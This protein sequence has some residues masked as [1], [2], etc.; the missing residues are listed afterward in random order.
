MDWNISSELILKDLNGHLVD[1]IK[2]TTD[3]NK[4]IE[5]IVK[6]NENNDL[7]FIGTNDYVNLITKLLNKISPGMEFIVQFILPMFKPLQMKIDIENLKV[8]EA[9]IGNKTIKVPNLSNI[10]DI[11]SLNFSHVSNFF[12][13]SK[14]I[15]SIEESEEEDEVKEEEEE[16]EEED[17]DEDEEEEEDEK[18]TNNEMEN[19]N[20]L[21]GGMNMDSSMLR[22]LLGGMKS[23][24]DKSVNPMNILGKMKD[25]WTND[26]YDN[27]DEQEDLDDF[28]IEDKKEDINLSKY[29]GFNKND[30]M[31]ELC[32]LGGGNGNTLINELDE[33][34]TE[35]YYNILISQSSIFNYNGLEKQIILDDDGKKYLRLLFRNTGIPSINFKFA[36]MLQIKEVLIKLADFYNN[37]KVD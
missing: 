25:I 22:G 11:D 34:F 6:K 14:Q 13:P 15:N 2:I 9:Y 37:K 20:N 23:D 28:L 21:F 1:A 5:L 26:F 35:E 4:S 17:E 16:E 7:C 27:T 32:I 30:I 31:F 33:Y 19:I 24:N 8:I 18:E 3:K 12:N 29:S 10:D 36:N